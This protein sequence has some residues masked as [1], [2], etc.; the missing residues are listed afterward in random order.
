MSLHQR[1]QSMRQKGYLS[2][3]QGNKSHFN[4]LV[5][6][7]HY[8]IN[9]DNLDSNFETWDL[10][11]SACMHWHSKERSPTLHFSLSSHIMHFYLCWEFNKFLIAHNTISLWK[12]WMANSVLWAILKHWITK[13][14]WYWYNWYKLILKMTT[15]TFFL[16]LICQFWSYSLILKDINNVKIA[17]CLPLWKNDRRRASSP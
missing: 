2:G 10:L 1:Y 5:L 8:I 11:E 12:I 9:S 6:R 7:I 15:R 17:F 3:S 16:F 14:V 13:K 4:Q